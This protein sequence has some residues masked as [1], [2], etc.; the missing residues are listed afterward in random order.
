MDRRRYLYIWMLVSVGIFVIIAA[1]A[2][3]LLN[4]IPAPEVTPT[5]ASVD[6][7]RRVSLADAK[8]AFDAG[9][10]VFV[11]VR[12]TPSYDSSHIPGALSIPLNELTNHLNEFDPSSWIIT[13][14]T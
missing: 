5:P 11:D 7:V 1:L 14:C 12:P 13:Y 2:L 10:A 9:S 3:A 4:R 6:Q 8:A